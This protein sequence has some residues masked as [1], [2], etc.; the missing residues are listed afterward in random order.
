MFR[1]PYLQEVRQNL[2]AAEVD[3]CIAGDLRDPEIGVRKPLTVMTSLINLYHHLH[4]Q[5]SMGQQQQPRSRKNR[6]LN[7]VFTKLSTEVCSSG[8]QSFA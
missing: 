7:H 5:K 4:G 1:L 3:L 8:C 2:L 6:Y